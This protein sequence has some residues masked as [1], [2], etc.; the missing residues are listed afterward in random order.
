[1]QVI[2]LAFFI[3][4]TEFAVGSVVSLF[5]LQ[6][7]NDSSINFFRTQAFINILLSLLAWATQNGFATPQQLR[8]DGF[9]LDFAWLQ[10]QP[11]LLG[12]FLWLQIP[13]NLVLFVREWR[14]AQLVIGTVITALGIATL[15]VIGMG[16]RPIA[17]AHLNGFFT[18]AIFLLGALSVGGVTTSMLLGHWY[19]NTPT[20]SGKPLEFATGLTIIGI[21]AQ[22][23]C[24]L[25]IGPAT[26]VAPKTASA[27]AQSSRIVHTP[28]HADPAPSAATTPT[29]HP[30]TPTKT[31]TQ[32]VPSGVTFPTWVL[33]LLQYV[34][35]LGV[36]LGLGFLALKL[37]R[38]RSFQSATGMLYIAVVFTFFGE[39]LA[40]G[41]FLRPLT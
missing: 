31:P 12:W 34:L 14:W 9:N 17:A 29:P 4:I 22:I 23:F 19:L 33:I 39:I 40:S 28:L 32:P 27:P 1:M 26:Y 5:A 24:G 7:R 8:L 30:T 18:V 36:P 10:H 15:L 37:E 21:V 6:V 38:E 41:L 13:Y 25:L 11:A 35:G 16:L 3:V 20:A 2:P